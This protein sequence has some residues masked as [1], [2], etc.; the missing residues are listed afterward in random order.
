[1]TI[2]TELQREWM[3]RTQT[4]TS[5]C[6]EFKEQAVDAKDEEMAN[7]LLSIEFMLCAMF[8][9][10][11]MWV[12]L[13]EGKAKEAWHN[14]VV[15]QGAARCAMKAHR[16]GAAME[17]YAVGLHR[18][19]HVVFPPQRFVSSAL[20]VSYYQCSIC[21][22]KYGDCGHVVGK[23]Y[24]GELC[25]RVPRDIV[26]VDHVAWLQDNDPADKRC[27]VES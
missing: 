26:S 8:N 11:S 20:V 15:A 24:M 14:L 5:K 23:P 19:E 18:I 13:K 1:M 4:Y 10:L 3:G 7:A 25:S 12:L 6:S 27:R 22:G 9:E 16:L 21:G 2:A 17:G